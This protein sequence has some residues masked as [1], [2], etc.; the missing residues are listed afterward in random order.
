MVSHFGDFG[1]QKKR[2]ER[3]K[4]KKKRKKAKKCMD[5]YGLV[6]FCMD[7]GLFHF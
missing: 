7:I 1:E 4:K 5:F 2:R 3:E 6:W